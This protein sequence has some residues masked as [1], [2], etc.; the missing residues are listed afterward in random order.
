MEEALNALD[1]KQIEAIAYDRALL[2]SVIKKDT[3]SKY[4]FIDIKYNPQFFAFG[5]SKN[6]PDTLVK[7]IN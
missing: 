4:K 3:L 2:K 6:L 5:L 7:A 1:N